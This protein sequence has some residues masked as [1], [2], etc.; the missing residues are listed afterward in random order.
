[1][2]APT[3]GTNG[4]LKRRRD[5]MDCVAVTGWGVEG[6]SITAQGRKETTP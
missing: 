1:M 4:G 6:N 3:F 2:V 5:P